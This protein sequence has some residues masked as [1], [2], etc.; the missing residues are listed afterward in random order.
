MRDTNLPQRPT[1]WIIARDTFGNARLVDRNIVVAGSAAGRLATVGGSLL[2]ECR[3]YIYSNPSRQY[4]SEIS[5][6][7]LYFH[8]GEEERRA[9]A[10]VSPTSCHPPCFRYFTLCYIHTGRRAADIL[11]AGNPYKETHLRAIRAISPALLARGTPCECR[12]D[13]A[14]R[15]WTEQPLIRKETNVGGHSTPP[16]LLAASLSSFDCSRK[17]ESEN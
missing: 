2:R 3:T 4:T 10:P 6:R 5:P 9:H 16:P 17:T 7:L 12:D 14:D 8:E 11:A 1:K 13:V 15:C